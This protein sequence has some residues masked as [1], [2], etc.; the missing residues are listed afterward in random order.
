MHIEVLEQD[1][2]LL[3]LR[4]EMPAA[5]LAE[6]ADAGL[7]V[8]DCDP[9]ELAQQLVGLIVNENGYTPWREPEI[10]EMR[11]DP[12][13]GLSFQARLDLLPQVALADYTG[14]EL[15]VPP[16]PVPDSD[17]LLERA[18]ELQLAQARATEVTRGIAWGDRVCLDL[19][20]LVGETPMP[21][22]ARADWEL[23]IEPGVLFAGFGEALLGLGAGDSAEIPLTLPMDYEYTAWRGREAVY[24]V[25]IR[26]VE[27]LEMPPLDADF[28]RLAGLGESPDEMMELLHEQLLT[29]YEAEWAAG[30][31]ELLLAKLVP[32]CELTPP[33]ALVE[34]ELLDQWRRCEYPALWDQGLDDELIEKSRQL[35]L[36]FR[37]LREQV[38][39]K[40]AVAL[41]LRAI[42]RREELSLDEQEWQQAL[43]EMAGALGTSSE[44]LGAELEAEGRLGPLADKLLLDKTLRWLVSKAR[45][46]CAEPGQSPGAQ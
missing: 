28:P 24:H 29:E 15:E 30:V 9:P 17:D 45:I 25:L 44:A 39:W 40:V 10:S 31:G 43:T 16:M 32:L 42:A 35:W 46:S 14:L 8:P 41:V 5:G 11:F 23:L 36:R 2:G 12:E 6:I 37:P 3:V 7:I 13:Q 26:R 33:P 4:A 20:A 19:I 34:A 21:L 38:L 1:F 22:S 27:E 18:A